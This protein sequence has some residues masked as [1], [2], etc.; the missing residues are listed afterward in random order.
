[1]DKSLELFFSLKEDEIDAFEKFIAHHKEIKPQHKILFEYII[2]SKENFDETKFSKK[3]NIQPQRIPYLKSEL[4]KIAEK[5]IV[6]YISMGQ[7]NEFDRNR[8]LL[9]FFDSHAAEK[10]TLSIL[11]TM[12]RF[13]EKFFFDSSEHLSLFRLGRLKDV[14]YKHRTNKSIKMESIDYAS[15]LD[16]FFALEKLKI[17]CEDLNRHT[18]FNTNYEPHIHLAFFESLKDK[19]PLLKI[20]MELYLVLSNNQMASKI[21]INEIITLWMEHSNNL[22][23]RVDQYT[24]FHYLINI[25]SR[26]IKKGDL[27][28]KID[29]LKLIEYADSLDLLKENDKVNVDILLLSFYYAIDVE[30]ERFVNF[31]YEKYKLDIEN[32][33]KNYL[34]PFFESLTLFYKEKY[35][36]ASRVFSGADLSKFTFMKKI[37]A[38]MLEIRIQ[39]ELEHSKSKKPI[40]N[41]SLINSRIKAIQHLLQNESIS[42]VNKN[43]IKL[44]CKQSA[45]I[46]KNKCFNEEQ[47]S[48]ET[49]F[50]EWF[51]RINKKS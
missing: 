38:Y 1:M 39:I 9:S 26:A 42:D 43:R 19:H 29:F 51:L 41:N 48:I 16:L 15:H 6:Q 12:D 10:N 25:I 46:N 45:S 27:E 20:Y 44:F 34:S 2:K 7:I 23:I 35:D 22:K 31:F 13:D 8:S 4:L 17:Y 50:Y 18:L 40:F 21:K 47:V 37:Q 30:E 33:S 3:N 49:P 5:W 32:S 24:I 28:L 36:E 11:K 14:V